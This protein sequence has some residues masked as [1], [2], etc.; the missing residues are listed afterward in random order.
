MRLDIYMAENSFGSRT[1][2]ARAIAEGRLLRNV[3]VACPADEVREG[4]CVEVQRA[5]ISFV[6]EG[7]FKLYKALSDFGESVRGGVF[8][9]IGASTG[10]F[11]DCL[12]QSGAK[13]VYCIDVGESLLDPS[14]RG[15]GRIV[16]QENVNARFLKK[17][18][19]PE[20]LDGIVI[21]VS[22]IRLELILPV[23]RDIV[24]PRGVVLAL[25]KPQFE[26]DGKRQLSKS[27]IV[28]DARRRRK[29]VERIY[30]ACL[31]NELY[32]Q[33]LVNAPL[34]ER[35]NVEYV[36]LLG[37]NKAACADKK[38]IGDK[39]DRLI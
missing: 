2:A 23:L 18:D 10:G 32:P 4:D 16:N 15:D 1:K 7:G 14:L 9:D 25:V 39:A 8:I 33:D 13:K 22:F 38:A 11:T 27:G 12:L 31:E 6:S 24:S 3:K 37:R 17:E 29:I 19:F 21:D 5:E 20:P 28:T 35:K 34:R 36:L 30:D 26:C